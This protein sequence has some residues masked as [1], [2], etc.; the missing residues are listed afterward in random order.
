MKIINFSVTTVANWMCIFITWK[1]KLFIFNASRKK[2]RSRN[3]PRFVFSILYGLRR[4]ESRFYYVD[5]SPHILQQDKIVYSFA[6]FVVD[7]ETF[8]SDF[9][10]L[11]L[12]SVK[13][14]QL[15]WEFTVCRIYSS[16]ERVI[17]YIDITLTDETSHLKILV[18]SYFLFRG[19]C[20]FWSRAK[21]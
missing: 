17:N 12:I 7:S 2:H 13:W 16:G 19:W 14:M 18:S 21:R 6:R 11:F 20:F 1:P 3:P 10:D 8:S 15:F 4:S 9:A 5:V